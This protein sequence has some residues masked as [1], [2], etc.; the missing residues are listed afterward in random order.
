[1]DD[2]SPHD[3]LVAALE[4]IQAVAEDNTQR[5]DAIQRRAQRLLDQLDADV[6]VAELMRREPGPRIVEL[7]SANLASLQDSGAHLRGVQA[8]ALREEGLTM[9]EI[10]DLFGVTRQRVSSLL[11]AAR[12]RGDDVDSA[13]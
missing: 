12:R 1:M 3:R 10:A 13:H 6:S 4:A 11:A 7:V 9:A 5:N 8:E 2:D